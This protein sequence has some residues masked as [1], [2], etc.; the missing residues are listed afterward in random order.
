MQARATISTHACGAFLARLTSLIEEIEAGL[1]VPQA[2][3]STVAQE[4]L[5]EVRYRG[6]LVGRTRAHIAAAA[7]AKGLRVFTEAPLS[8]TWTL[9]E[10]L[11]TFASAMRE[12]GLSQG[13][14][15]E[16]LDLCPLADND[17]APV[18][19]L[20]RALFRPIGATTR[21]VHFVGLTRRP[22]SAQDR[23]FWLGLRSPK[24]RIGPGL[25]DG[26][27]AG[28]VQAGEAPAVALL[29]EAAEEA[30]VTSE[31]IKDLS[32]TPI[33]HFSVSR[34]VPEGWMREVAEAAFAVLPEGF[35]PRAVDGEVERFTCVSAEELVELNAAH[36]MMREAGLTCLKAAKYLLA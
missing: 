27:A 7:A 19:T 33:A 24:K 35:T 15:G 34:P 31:V 12:A 14:R 18:G 26:L 11:T 28:M 8:G 10:D 5:V 29:R 25:W 20:E 9:P 30:G 36:A 16:A 32:L 13:W 22:Q 6:K 17:F 3:E 23:V 21:A 4:P 2:C 1:F